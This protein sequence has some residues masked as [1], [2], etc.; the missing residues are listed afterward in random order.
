MTFIP[1][2]YETIQKAKAAGRKAEEYL[3]W[4]RM[5]SE[6][7]QGLEAIVHRKELERRAGDGLFCWGVGNAP[8]V[9]TSSLA[10]LGQP[11]EVVFSIMKGRPK[12]VDSA[13]SKVVAWRRYIDAEGVVRPLPANVLVTSRADTV[14]GPK[15]KHFA[16]MCGSREP[17]TIKR[18]EPFDPSVYRNAGGAGAPVGA[19]Q[20]TALL[21]RTSNDVGNSDYEANLRAWLVESYWVR[22]IDPVVCNPE[23]EAVN[24]M[25]PNDREGWL[26]FVSAVRAEDQR[27]DMT[28]STALLL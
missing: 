2:S 28:T 23:F 8:A 7:G 19:S 17:L 13:P 6:A 25:S 12:A 21:K 1:T 15:T 20:V 11:I 27:L 16:L 10:R 4:S 26:D 9:V 5:Q 24:G 18:G 14:A 3:C 22:L